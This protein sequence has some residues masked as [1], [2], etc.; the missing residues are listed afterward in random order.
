VDD[1]APD[2]KRMRLRYDGTCRTCEAALPANTEAVYDRAS[3]TVRC[4]THDEPVT[5]A[6]T[7]DEPVDPGTPGGSARRG[8]ERARVGR[9]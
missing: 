4:L 7:K 5:L 6:P 2:E 3:K 8:V 9:E 1:L